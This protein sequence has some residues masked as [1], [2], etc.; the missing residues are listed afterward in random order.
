MMHIL[1]SLRDFLDTETLKFLPGNLQSGSFML[2][3]AHTEGQSRP[4]MPLCTDC[5]KTLKTKRSIH[6][7]KKC[8]ESQK[9]WDQKYPLGEPWKQVI[10]VFDH[11]GTFIGTIPDPEFIPSAK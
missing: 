9:E 7:C 10:H 11:I 4:V 8:I 2:L 6:L 1:R 3:R 5:A